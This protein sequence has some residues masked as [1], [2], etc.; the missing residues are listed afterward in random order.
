MEVGV[1]RLANCLSYSVID[2]KVSSECSSHP[3]CC[4][5]KY[6]GRVQWLTRNF[7]LLSSSRIRPWN[8]SQL[9]SCRS[10]GP[11]SW[12]LAMAS[13]SRLSWSWSALASL[14]DILVGSSVEASVRSFSSSPAVPSWALVE[15]ASDFST[16]TFN[17]LSL[18]Y[19]NTVNIFMHTHQASGDNPR[20]PL[21]FLSPPL[22]SSI[23]W[24]THGFLNVFSLIDLYLMGLKKI[25]LSKNQRCKGATLCFWE[26]L[27][28][29]KGYCCSTKRNEVQITMNQD[30]YLYTPIIDEKRRLLGLCAVQV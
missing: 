16:A 5:P 8:L 19:D 14:D 27:D 1:G 26:L 25:G 17:D 9:S 30:G 18:V 29:V 21:L 28:K 24:Y 6:T 4:C 20:F 13:R 12:V 15:A 22:L 2:A 11:F 23:Q 3:P 7:Q 10:R